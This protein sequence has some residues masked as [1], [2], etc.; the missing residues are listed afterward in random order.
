MDKD[1]YFALVDEKRELARKKDGLNQQWERVMWKE[2]DTELKAV[3]AE[4]ETLRK[5]IQSIN[6]ALKAMKKDISRETLAIWK[7]E[8]YLTRNRL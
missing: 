1:L 3:E 7:N 5:E 6:K 4:Q 8:Y 2:D